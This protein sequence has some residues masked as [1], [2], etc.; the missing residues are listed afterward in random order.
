MN[1]SQIPE[2][3]TRKEAA[4]LV[5]VCLTSLDKMRLPVIRIGRRV[6]YRKATLENWLATH[7]QFK[8]TNLGRNV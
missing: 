2:V 3:L 1:S 4:S 8:E 7:E 5:R 6:F